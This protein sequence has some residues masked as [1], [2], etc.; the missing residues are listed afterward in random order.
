MYLFTCLSACSC[1]YFQ[2]VHVFLFQHVHKPFFC[3]FTYLF[4]SLFTNSFLYVHV[5]VFQPVHVP[6]GGKRIPEADLQ[7]V[8]GPAGQL[9]AQYLS[10]REPGRRGVDRNRRLPGRHLSHWR[11]EPPVQ[12]PGRTRWLLHIPLSGTYHH[13]LESVCLICQL[14]EF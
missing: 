4:F 3:M 13:E 14:C 9:H 1:T 8:P 5:P 6:A 12:L 11:H 10:H 7:H 2:S